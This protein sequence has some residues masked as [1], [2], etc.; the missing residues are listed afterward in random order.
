MTKVSDLEKLTGL[1]PKAARDWHLCR[2]YLK[3]QN[4]LKPLP[5]AFTYCYGALTSLL[6]LICIAR[7][8]QHHG[9]DTRAQVGIPA[10]GCNSLESPHALP[11]LAL[12][13]ATRPIPYRAPLAPNLSSSRDLG[14]RVRTTAAALDAR[15]LGARADL[16]A[17]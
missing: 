10:P 11:A 16:E 2:H 3:N 5:S 14:Y 13:M 4:A 15:R 12:Q 7:R 8:V 17:V 6:P 9:L 1:T